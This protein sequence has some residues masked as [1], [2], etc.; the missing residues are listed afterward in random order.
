MKYEKQNRYSFLKIVEFFL[1]F[2]S[3][4]TLIDE[5]SGEHLKLMKNVL[6]LTAKEELLLNRAFLV[7]NLYRQDIQTEL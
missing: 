4:K 1:T 7:T 6:R 2:E 5:I 3:E